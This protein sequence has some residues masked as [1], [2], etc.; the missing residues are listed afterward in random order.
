VLSLCCN[1]NGGVGTELIDEGPDGEGSTDAT[2]AFCGFRI[3][4]C[5][6]LVKVCASFVSKDFVGNR[7][8]G[9]IFSNRRP[10]VLAPSVSWLTG[11]VSCWAETVGKDWNNESRAVTRPNEIT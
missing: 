11:L 2:G 9:A 4:R 6:L 7:R 3:N 10:C 1:D 8:V 5:G